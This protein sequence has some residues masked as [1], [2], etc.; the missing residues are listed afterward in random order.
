MQRGLPLDLDR[1]LLLEVKPIVRCGCGAQRNDPLAMIVMY[2]DGKD[3]RH[4]PSEV[5]SWEIASSF[6]PDFQK[7]ALVVP[8]FLQLGTRL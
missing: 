1:T 6:C 2:C 7:L 5:T 8:V 3:F 4:E